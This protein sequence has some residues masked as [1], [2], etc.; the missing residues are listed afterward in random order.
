MACEGKLSY[1]CL[2]KQNVSRIIEIFELID[3]LISFQYRVMFQWV[4]WCKAAWQSFGTCLV[5][6]C[7]KIRFPVKDADPLFCNWN[8]II[9]SIW[10]NLPSLK[11]ENLQEDKVCYIRS[12]TSFLLEDLLIFW[13][14][15]CMYTH[16]VKCFSDSPLQM[17]SLAHFKWRE[18]G[19]KICRAQE[20]I[21]VSILF[22]C[23]VL[24][25]EADS[26]SLRRLLCIWE[27]PD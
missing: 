25:L 10:A 8:V 12:I 27:V 24:V 22:L 4:V 2:W 3:V 19:R 23:D 1:F 13:Y 17:H 9:G 6:K 7:N 16:G 26:R 18:N 11:W 5:H 21:A 14:L 15:V 20:F